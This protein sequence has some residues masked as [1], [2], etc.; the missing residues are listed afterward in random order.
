MNLIKQALGTWWS[1]LL[2]LGTGAIAGAVFAL[3][4]LPVPAPTALPGIMGILGILIGYVII[5]LIR[6]YI[7]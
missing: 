1:N 2:A 7:K 5:Q 3:A 6:E 4:K